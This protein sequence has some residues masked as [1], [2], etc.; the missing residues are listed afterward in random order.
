MI[1]TANLRAE[2][3]DLWRTCEIRP[4]HAAEVDQVATR[5]L[6][7][8]GRYE[9]VEASIEVPWVVVAVIHQMESSGRFDCH[10]HNGDPLTARTVHYPTSRPPGDPPF[11]W[12]ESAADALRIRNL[13]AW[14]DWSAA[15]LLYEIEGWNGFG[16]RTQ[17]PEVLTP[18]LWSFSNHYTAG[19]FVADHQWSATAVSKQCGAATML[20][21][22]VEQGVVEVTV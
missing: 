21:R 3:Q 8:Q 10:L 7:H 13:P 11:T 22:L 1:L 20:R 18:Y 16:Y 12:E 15:G 2:Y 4:A 19:K 5:I 14:N 9:A 17:H 6:A